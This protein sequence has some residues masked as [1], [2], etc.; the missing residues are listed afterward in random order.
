MTEHGEIVLFPTGGATPPATRVDAELILST[1]KAEHPNA[2]VVET[3]GIEIVAISEKPTLRHFINAGIYLLNPEIAGYVPANQ[4]YDMPDLIARLIS[5]NQR[6]IS[7]P[8][9]EYW[10]DIGQADDYQQAIKDTPSKQG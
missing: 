9:H 5:D 4:S 8:V 10:L 6:V 2:R 7:F 1:F 3:N